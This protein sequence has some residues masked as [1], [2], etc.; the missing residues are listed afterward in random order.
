VSFA[1]IEVADGPLRRHRMFC[2]ARYI[3]S[4]SLPHL[5][6]PEQTFNARTAPDLVSLFEAERVPVAW[7]T[8]SARWPPIDT[9]AIVGIVVEVAATAGMFVGGNPMKFAD[10][11]V[12]AN[13]LVQR[14]K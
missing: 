12:A 6:Q 13:H 5:P 4:I 2:P 1:L 10:E 11:P 8:R 9:S 7:P 14:M 3:D